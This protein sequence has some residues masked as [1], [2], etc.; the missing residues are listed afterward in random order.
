M[1]AMLC[2]EQSEV[3]I[4]FFF[5]FQANRTFDSLGSII[6]LSD[7][8]LETISPALYKYLE[9]SPNIEFLRVRIPISFRFLFFNF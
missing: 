5:F 3:M 9:T 6:D 1:F 7:Q 8:W 2:N 4:S